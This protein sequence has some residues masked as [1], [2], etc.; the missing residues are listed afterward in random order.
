M[1]KNYSPTD[2]SAVLNRDLSLP[3][4]DEDATL[5]SAR[6][7]VPLH[8]VKAATRS[9]RRVISGLTIIA[10]IV[11]GAIS[12]TLLLTQGGQNQERS[13]EAE[14]SK[15]DLPFLGAAGGSAPESA[16]A[17]EPALTEPKPELPTREVPS[18]RSS[19]ATK[20]PTTTISRSPET[21]VRTRRSEQERDEDFEADERAW[22]Q[23]DR[24]SARREARR[25]LR[26]RR[27]RSGDE[28]MRIREIFEGSRP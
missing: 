28:L 9:R 6:P 22:R 14:M 21:P 7:V 19:T 20:R 25:E 13:A 4:F 16:E 11:A 23:S 1:E 2:Y 17:R 24:R 5:L 3:H 8:E 10:A 27:D 18:V 26:R 15:P 12:A